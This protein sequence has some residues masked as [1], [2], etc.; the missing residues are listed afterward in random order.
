MTVLAYSLLPLL[1]VNCLIRVNVSSL[2]K[3]RCIL[4]LSRISFEIYLVHG[5]IINFLRQR[6]DLSG[7]I[8]VITTIPITLVGAFLFHELTHLCQ[9]PIELKKHVI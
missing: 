3:N 5:I 2:A 4:F 6:L 1:L 8:L 7:F 9:K